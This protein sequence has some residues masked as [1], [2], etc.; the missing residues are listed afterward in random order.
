MNFALL[1]SGGTGSRMGTNVPKQYIPVA[2]Y[3]IVTRALLQ[4]AKHPLID[5]LQVVAA[6]SWRESILEDWRKALPAEGLSAEDP[7]KGNVLHFSDPGENRQ[8]SILNGLRDIMQRAGEEDV[9][10]VH[11]A[12]RPALAEDTIRAC[13]D[14]CGEHDGAM[15]V[16]PMKDTVYYSES[17]QRVDRLLDRGKIFAGQA[18]EAYR[19]GRYLKANEE[20]LP[21][22]IL[23]ICG[24]TEPAVL[25]G[26]DIAMI[27]GDEG[28]FKIT[29][30]GDLKRYIV[31]IE[32]G[33]SI[34]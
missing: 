27:P 28:N 15:P 23:S 16:L 20:L 10:L 17:G 34:G 31:M 3:M 2:G 8:S 22:R 1:L 7:E 19:L 6:P 12:A 4:L 18:P 24:S 11:D 25:A 30:P 32:A 9:V 26:M 21:D 29:T 33:E 14:A 5:G 13:L